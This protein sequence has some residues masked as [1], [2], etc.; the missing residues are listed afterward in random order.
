MIC[1]RKRATWFLNVRLPLVILCGAIV[2]IGA[3]QAERDAVLGHLNLVIRLYQDS[4]VKIETGGLPSDL[5]FQENTQSLAT[6]AVRLAFQS[7]RAEAALIDPQ[8][9]AAKGA[10]TSAQ[11]G[12]ATSASSGKTKGAVTVGSA[13]ATTGAST[14]NEASQSAGQTADGSAP[15]YAVVQAQV[16]KRIDDAQS[17]IDEL[18]KKISVT[19]GRKA[20]PLISQRD[21]LQGQLSLDRAMLATVQQLASFVENNSEGDE[22]LL[23][24]INEL[25]RSVPEVAEV[26]PSSKTAAAKRPEATTQTQA[27]EPQP[28]GL[29]GQMATLYGQ[30][31]SV[32]T[33]DRLIS[34]AAVVRQSAN[35]LSAPLRDSIRKTIQSGQGTTSQSG[36]Q[37]AAQAAPSAEQFAALTQQFNQL[38]AALVPLREEMV[39]LDQFRGNLVEWRHSLSTES[40]RTLISLL[41]RIAGIALALGLVMI[42]SEIW[43]RATFR[44][45]H[46]GRRRRQILV[47]RRFVVG[48]F[49]S[50]VIVLGIVSGFSSLATFA[51][52][53]TAGVAVGL[54]TV[55]LSVAAYF[56]VVGRY[57]IRVGDRISVAGVT[58]DVADVG[59]V[60][61]YLIEMAG[62][63]VDLY[64]TGRIA[65]FSNS[66]LFQPTTPLYKQIPGT[67]YTWHEISLTL[68][69]VGD[70]K[71][72]QE[73]LVAAVN[74]VYQKYRAAIERQHGSIEDRMEV[75]LRA[76][77]PEIKLQLGDAG[78]ELLARYPVDLRQ[79]SEMDDEV[80]RAVLGMLGVD[81]KLRAAVVGTPRIRAA[82][83]G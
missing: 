5:I 22:G 15:N 23:G 53:A 63:G 83:K 25:A 44:Y 50:V 24:S 58:G 35:N 26:A 27:A 81:E 29:F 30:V 34:E 72:V 40:K 79:A 49:I 8:T 9:D 38:A 19:A 14:K 65:V 46:D 47:L 61:L 73:K 36:A 28:S 2:A 4:T 1:K 76:P 55:L 78:M 11:P 3:E 77:S 52:F 7:A 12:T 60:R 59:L 57:G 54:Q 67:E 70:Y 51:G 39:V 31:R 6:E 69:P 64:P 43:R 62:T 82:I 20:K 75:V 74:S 41:V 45:V 33:I 21:A 32:Q 18:D 13:S 42:L 66:V 10:L 68:A 17:Q 56:F 71:L 16:E 37:P 48:F 80:A